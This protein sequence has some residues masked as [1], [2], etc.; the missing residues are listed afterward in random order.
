[1]ESRWGLND[2]SY[3]KLRFML[4]YEWFKPISGDNTYIYMLGHTTNEYY[5]FVV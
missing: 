4:I 1:M 3:G 2:L 5:R